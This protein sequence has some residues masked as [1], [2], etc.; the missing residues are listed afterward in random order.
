MSSIEIEFPAAR[1]SQPCECCGGITTTLNRFVKIDGEPSAIY[2]LRFSDN[3][4]N[5]LVL[6]LFGIGLFGDGTT[7][8]DRVA[9]AV[10]LRPEG[11]MVI[12]AEESQWPKSEILGRRLTRAEAMVRPEL[13]KLYAVVDSMYAEDEPL[14]AYLRKVASA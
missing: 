2:R 14:R 9:F 8:S 5:D 7:N 10:S 1:L 4:P 6:G 13:S 11:V 12:D 3:H